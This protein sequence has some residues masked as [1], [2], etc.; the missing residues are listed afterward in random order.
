VYHC[1]ALPITAR[2]GN[3]ELLMR[4]A[5]IPLAL[6]ACAVATIAGAQLSQEYS[7]WPSS[8][9]GHL[10]T[11]AERK[12]YEQ[13][14]SD[15]EAKAF[16]ELFW[17]KRDP[18]LETPLNEFKSGF[19]MRVEAADRYFTFG[20]T[21]GSMSDR[22]RVLIMLGKFSSRQMFRPGELAAQLG[23][24]SGRGDDTG[25]NEVWKFAK[26]LLPDGFKGDE[27]I[28]V[29][30]ETGVGFGDFILDRTDRRNAGAMKVLP[31]VQEALV[32]NP[33]ITEVPRLGLLPG[34]KMATAQQL[35]V[36]DTQP[37]PW[38]DG[39]VVRGYA[40]VLSEAIHP[41]WLFVQLPASVPQ[42]TQVI[43]R[44]VNASSGED[45][46]SFVVAAKP[47]TSAG[48]HA[49]EFAFPLDP[50]PWRVELA[51]LN[52]TEPVAIASHEGVSETVPKEGT[53]MSPLYWGVDIRQEVGARL[54]DPMNIGGWHVV[55]RV[56]DTYTA[57]EQL[58]YFCFVIR[59]GIPEAVA[60]ADPA[61]PKPEAK[62]K[63]EVSMVLMAG[64]K[65][66]SEV[67]ATPV[68]VSNING[69]LWMFGNGLPLEGFRK[70]G[71]YR[72]EVTLRDTITN[73]SRTT[74]IP[75]KIPAEPAAAPTTGS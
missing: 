2:G 55:P 54:G 33:K 40:G 60:S 32:V 67:P 22:G 48:G 46:G 62:P 18:D 29:F 14:K 25:N 12:A 75:V 37:R 65:K 10:L 16:I 26:A 11:K 68:N 47:F 36:L 28:F 23:E 58:S 57:R 17:A 1:A 5:T 70:A 19:D 31:L 42:A 9:A 3:E 27:A 73:V 35:A 50:G 39:C 71:D 64:E 38:P 24:R 51:L 8:P 43:G 59:P 4:Y 20:Q 21:K 52:G 63:L 72:L 53:Y 61:A 45:A 44:V 56:D 41:L 49:Y 13:I 69:A 15:G 30:T 34:S 74:S 6:A 66:L 7:T